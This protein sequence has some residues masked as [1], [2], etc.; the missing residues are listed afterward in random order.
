MIIGI[1]GSIASGK[2]T[3]SKIIS[4]GKGPLFSADQVVKKLYKNNYFKKRLKKKLRLASNINIK[5]AI[6]EKIFSKEKSVLRLLEQIIHPFVRKEMHLFIEKNKNKSIIFLEIPLL[7]ESKLMKY[8]DIIIFIRSSINVRK[9][10]YKKKGGNIKLFNIL[11]T[12]Q[13]HE[14]RKIKFCDHIVVNN[15]SLFV[16]K[17]NLLHIIKRYE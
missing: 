2:T 10:R 8:F 1:T 11:N 14:N 3:A 9:K 12:H 7:I 5:K 17:K 6:K 13:L 16:L 15:K 4:A